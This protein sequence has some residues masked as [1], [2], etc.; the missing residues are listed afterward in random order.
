MTTAKTI[1]IVDDEPTIRLTMARILQREGY[2][3]TTAGSAHEAIQCLQSGPY[4]LTFLD[5]QMPEMDGVTLLTEIRRVFPGMPIVILT[6]HGTLRSSIEAVRHGV[7]DYLLKPVDPAIILTR[8]RAILREQEQSV[9]RQEIIVQIQNL[10]AELQKIDGTETPTAN[11]LTALS[12]TRFLQR[13]PF[14]LDL[15]ARHAM[16]DERILSLSPTSFDYLVTL[17]RHSPDPV[18]YETLVTE[19][20]GYETSLQEAMELVR[21]H[22]HQLRQAIEPEPDNP[23]FIL[24]VRSVG[25]RL[26][27]Q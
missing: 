26:V 16:L 5:L 3:V 15:H 23:R 18:P 4:A 8:T 25:Y 7:R 11:L 13:G 24:T 9:R 27:T 20:Q 19:T 21:W 2:S 17:A 14:T 12:S 22:M 1:L 10:I 6:G